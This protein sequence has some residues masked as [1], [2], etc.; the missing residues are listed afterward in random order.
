M[1]RKSALA[2]IGALLV[3]GSVVAQTAD[4]SAAPLSAKDKKHIE[5]LYQA[6]QPQEG[7]AGVSA[8]EML[9]REEIAAYRSEGGWG[10]AFQQ[11]QDDGYFEDY[12]NFGQVISLSKSNDDGSEDEPAIECPT[13]CVAGI[14]AWRTEAE[15]RTFGA[16]GLSCGPSSIVS[17]STWTGSS[18]VDFVDLTLNVTAGQC[19]SARDSVFGSTDATFAQVALTGD[20]QQ[21]CAPIANE[22]LV[23]LQV[24]TDAE[25]DI[26]P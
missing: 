6:Q 5:A 18:P 13:D 23:L 7:T 8:A 10:E 4:S 14:A 9:T 19:K 17:S 26:S 22:T 1:L 20:Q 25:C 12:K 15:L 24:T 3:A 16:V 2:L 21:A 11:M